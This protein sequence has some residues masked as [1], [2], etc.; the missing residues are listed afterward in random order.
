MKKPNK[1]T[2]LFLVI[3]ILGVIGFVFFINKTLNKKSQLDLFPKQY[4]TQN[5]SVTFEE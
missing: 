4:N 2:L 1:L 3:F 5:S